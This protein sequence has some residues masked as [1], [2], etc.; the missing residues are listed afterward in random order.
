LTILMI[1]TSYKNSNTAT[2]LIF[3]TSREIKTVGALPI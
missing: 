2:M 3:Y 1:R